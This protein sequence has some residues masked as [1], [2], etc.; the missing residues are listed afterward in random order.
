MAKRMVRAYL[1]DDNSIE[2]QFRTL[3]DCIGHATESKNGFTD[4]LL[5]LGFD[6]ENTDQYIYT[7]YDEA[8]SSI[9]D[10][11][12]DLAIVP[13]KLVADFN[14]RKEIYEAEFGTFDG[15]YFEL[16]EDEL[17]TLVNDI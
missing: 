2:L 16:N 9:F 8:M 1:K 3:L 5:S 12:N 15:T 4:Y 10:L 13:T 17:K 7:S 11:S 14:A 6:L